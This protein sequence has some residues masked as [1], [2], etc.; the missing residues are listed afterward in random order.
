[1]KTKAFAGLAGV[2]L[3]SAVQAGTM[4]ATPAPA[5]AGG[6]W[7]W[8]VG[9]SVGYLT[10][11][12]EGMYGLQAG[13]EY[14]APEA[15][16][17]HA[18]YLEIGFTSDDASYDYR[19]RP[20]I[21]GARTEE[22]EIDVNLIPITLNYRYQAALTEHWNGYMGLGLGVV[23]TDTSYDWDWSQAVA[24]PYNRGGG[25]EDETDVRFY[26]D[27]FA[28][29]SYELGESCELFAGARWIFMDD[30]D[31]EID[32]TGA[33]SHTVGIDGDVLLEI[34]ARFRF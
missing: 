9:G 34:G 29:L 12:E 10:D 18:V 33:S 28:G 26:G 2:V 22:A 27:I 4:P 1:M 20:G 31:R 13:M 24:P 21:T 5:P 25:S 14:R 19:P 32:V 23:V 3:V 11:L 17:S 8:F 7:Q 30:D 6:L 15:R 16:A